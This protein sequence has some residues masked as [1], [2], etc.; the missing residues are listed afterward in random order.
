MLG[1]FYIL[2]IIPVFSDKKK[3]RMGKFN[4]SLSMQK[5]LTLPLIKDHFRLL[6]NYPKNNK[7][8]ENSEID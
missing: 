3:S 2:N 1:I 6:K 5:L 8:L 7:I 4:T